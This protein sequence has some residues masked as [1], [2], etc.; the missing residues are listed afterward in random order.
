ML[1]I[2]YL[3]ILAAFAALSLGL[4]VLCEYLMGGGR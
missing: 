2:V 4:V 1:D 3:L